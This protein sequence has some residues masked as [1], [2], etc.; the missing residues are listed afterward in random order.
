MQGDPLKVGTNSNLYLISR[1]GGCLTTADSTGPAISLRFGLNMKL[2][3]TCNSCSTVP[4]LF[5][6]LSGAAINQFSGDTSKNITLP[7]V[8]DPNITDLQITI[9]IGTYGSQGIRYI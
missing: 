2:T 9:V 7:S 5:S 6:V 1:I 4:Q 3:C 8:T